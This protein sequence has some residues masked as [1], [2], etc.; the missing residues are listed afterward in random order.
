MNF[1]NDKWI[2]DNLLAHYMDAEQHFPQNNIVVLALQ[3][4][5]NYGLDVENSD[6]DTK[7]IITPSLGD[8]IMNKQPVSTTFIR[9][10]NE[11]IDFKDI[12]LMFRTFEKQNL[13]FIEILFSPYYLVSPL[14]KDLWDKMIKNKELIAHYS[15][16]GA[17]KT[18]KGIALEKYHAMEHAYPSKLEIIERYG[19]DT[20]QLHH[21][22]R[23][24]EFIKRYIAGESYADCL[25]S[26]KPEELK[27]LK[28]HGYMDLAAARSLAEKTL[29]ETVEIA[30]AFIDAHKNDPINADAEKVLNDVQY[31]IMYRSIE[32]EMNQRKE[33]S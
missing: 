3:G 1:H 28:T 2:N 31:K 16:A 26:N 4:S 22:V 11:H 9:E 23:V 25:V 27:L 21:L 15:P 29:L 7:L 10:N 12:R 5:Q 14:Y 33:S 18:M 30:N 20:K 19:Y 6:I 8:L 24:N 13:N 17:V 32:Y